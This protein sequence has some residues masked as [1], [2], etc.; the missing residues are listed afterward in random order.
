MKKHLDATWATWAMGRIAYETNQ[1]E[2]AL[3]TML[4]TS[5]WSQ[6]QPFASRYEMSKKLFVTLRSSAILPLPP[7]RGE[8]QNGRASLSKM[9]K[10]CVRHLQTMRTRWDL[11]N[12]FS[13]V[14][15]G[16][17][18]KVIQVPHPKAK[19]DSTAF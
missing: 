11:H 12:T 15:E 5:L 4:M 17:A 8:G 14:P 3:S 7:L 13:E 2:A 1:L 18:G 6:G 16:A 19:G 9:E 10:C